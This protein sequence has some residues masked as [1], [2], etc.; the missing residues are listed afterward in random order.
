MK[1][2][3]NIMAKASK[4]IIIHYMFTLYL[5]SGYIKLTVAGLIYLAIFSKQFIIASIQ[6]TDRGFFITTT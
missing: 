3:E 1:Y 4:Y 6:A 5:L 2:V